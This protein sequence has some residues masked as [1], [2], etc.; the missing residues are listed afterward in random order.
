MDSFLI[1]KT[2]LYAFRQSHEAFKVFWVHLN[3]FKDFPKSGLEPAIGQPDQNLTV[4]AVR[5]TDLKVHRGFQKD[6]HNKRCLVKNG[7]YVEPLLFLDRRGEDR[8]G[9][10]ESLER[11]RRQWEKEEIL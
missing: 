4:G 11:Y 6:L 7:I 9:N 10:Q 5:T 3:L 8:T 2:Y 1:D